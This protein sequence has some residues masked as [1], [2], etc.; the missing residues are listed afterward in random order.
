[1]YGMISNLFEL[2]AYRPADH[3]EYIN[4]VGESS[5]A[6]KF[7]E[8]VFQ[9]S[10]SCILL[11]KNLNCLRL[12]R[13]KHWNLTKKYII[14]NTKHPVATGGTPITTWLPNQLGATLEYMQE[15]VEHVNPNDLTRQEDQEYFINLKI[16]LSDHIQSIMDEVKSMQ[17]DFDDQNYN[18]FTTRS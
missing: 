6:L 17:R 5:K 11:L 15:V 7:K 2:R 13:K 3:Q 18:D 4:F 8:Y 9:D 16:E 1:M 14:E 12:F 10:Y